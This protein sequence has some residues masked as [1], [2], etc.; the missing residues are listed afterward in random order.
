M[1]SGLALRVAARTGLRFAAR[2]WLIGRQLWHEMT[3]TLFL[4][5]GA[6]AIPTVIREWRGGSRS[7]ALMAS[8]FLATMVYFGVTSF[9]RARKAR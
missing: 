7:R 2:L 1:L 4:V 6:W 5:L 8:G 3:G 9:L